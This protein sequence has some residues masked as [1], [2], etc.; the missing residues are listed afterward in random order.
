MTTCAAN[1]EGTMSLAADLRSS[2]VGLGTVILCGKGQRE[3]RHVAE[4]VIHTVLFVHST[5]DIRKQNESDHAET[6]QSLHSPVVMTS[7][8]LFRVEVTRQKKGV[9]NMQAIQYSVDS[10]PITTPKH[11]DTAIRYLDGT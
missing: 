10:P 2:I 1:H 7:R 11:H 4:M 6:A 8:I 3:H 5:K 9:S